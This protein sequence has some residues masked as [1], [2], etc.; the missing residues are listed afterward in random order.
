[1]Q[2]KAELKRRSYTRL[3][4]QN[5]D[6]IFQRLNAQ[7]TIYFRNTLLLNNVQYAGVGGNRRSVADGSVCR[8][9]WAVHANYTALVR[10]RSYLPCSS[11]Q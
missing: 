10:G 3:R 9:S 2:R 1:M 4:T 11:A 5:T 7:T 6:S 8:S